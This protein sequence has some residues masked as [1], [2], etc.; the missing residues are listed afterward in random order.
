MQYWWPCEINS[1]VAE[2]ILVVQLAALQIAEL[3]FSK[4][5]LSTEFGELTIVILFAN[6]SVR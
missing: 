5:I 3:L 4:L 2:L 1:T 6:L